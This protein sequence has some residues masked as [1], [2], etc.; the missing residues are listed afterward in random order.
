MDLIFG[1]SCANTK[2]TKY[3]ATFPTN[4]T[5]Q[6]NNKNTSTIHSPGRHFPVQCCPDGAEGCQSP[7]S[8]VLAPALLP[9]PQRTA[10]APDADSLPPVEDQ[11]KVRMVKM[12]FNRKY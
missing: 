5:K 7:H 12:Q 8:A 10:A 3:T 11:E 9:A 4:R 1:N 2:T 6:N